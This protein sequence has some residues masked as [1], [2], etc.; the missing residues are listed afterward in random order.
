MIL[1]TGATGN[2][3]KEL[4]PQLLEAGERVRVFV[5]DRGKVAD[6]DKSIE[7]VQGD[8]DRPDTIAA[9]VDG[10]SSIY[11]IA[12]RTRQVEDILRTARQ[13][14]V[15]KIVKQ[16]TIEAG[17]V[18]PLGPGKWHREQE[19]LIE[20]SGLAWTHL[21]PTMMMVNTAAWWAES[22]RKQG[23]VWF[24][25]GGGRVS[26]VAPGDIA[27]VAVAVLS[28]PSHEGRAYDV[29]GPALLT[30]YEMVSILSRVLGKPIQYQD[31]P[32]TVAAEW[33]G[34]AGLPAYVQA[35]LVETLGAL[36]RSQYA[37]V[38]DTVER[39]TGRRGQSYEAWCREHVDLFETSL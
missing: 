16:S 14:G 15:R 30:V 29:T 25:G 21:R 38:A 37:Y 18:P 17:A 33:M 23:C 19:L 13:A 31:V 28:Q 2:V 1:V 22:I 39:L 24:P 26:P 11:L 27:A 35:G 12:S 34:K 5:R 20:G 8:L 4:V 3:G 32:E 9:A 6:L 10:M 36:R 7:V